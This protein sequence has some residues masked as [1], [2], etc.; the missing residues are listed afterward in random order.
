VIGEYFK[1]GKYFGKHVAGRITTM[2]LEPALLYFDLAFR[3]SL[4]H[5]LKA[6][7]WGAARWTAIAVGQL[8]PGRGTF[9]E[10]VSTILAKIVTGAPVVL[11]CAEE[12]QSRG[13]ARR[14]CARVRR[15]LE[16]HGGGRE[17]ADDG[18]DDSGADHGAW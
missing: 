13:R 12:V 6:K 3:G 14:G 9:R 4:R 17:K 1:T 7:L 2:V 8:C 16:C 15:S 11:G 10:D 18:D 5:L